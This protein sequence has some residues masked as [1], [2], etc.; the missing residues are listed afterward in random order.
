MKFPKRIP[1]M[2]WILILWGIYIVVWTMLES[3]LKATVFA[4]LLIVLVISGQLFNRILGD[5]TIATISGLLLTSLS[6]VCI[7]LGVG[8][9]T[10]ALMALKTGLHAH[11]PEFSA[12]EVNWV[13][14][15]IPLWTAAGLLGGIGCG[16]ILTA[17]SSPVD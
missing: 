6:G 1:A 10:L 11:G 7:G 14:E 8:L 2:K 12:A 15:Q 17:R 13:I 4:A 3:G 5:R 16:L 9:V